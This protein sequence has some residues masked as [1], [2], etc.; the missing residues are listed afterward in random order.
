MN[1]I[2]ALV[3]A[4]VGVVGLFIRERGLRQTAESLLQNSAVKAILSGL[5]DKIANN[6]SAIS[7]EEKIAQAIKEHIQS[8]DQSKPTD[9]TDITD[10]FNN[11]K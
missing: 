9:S 8:N 5:L 2:I 11:L 6:N 7:A 10:F 3:L 4:L 1:A